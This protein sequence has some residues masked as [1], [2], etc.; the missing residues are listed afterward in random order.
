VSALT[1]LVL[2]SVVASVSEW[3]KISAVVSDVPKGG[4]RSV[5]TD[6]IRIVLAN[7][8]GEIYALEDVCSHQELPLSDG[9]LEG[10]R[11]ECPFHGAKF[12]VRTGRALNLPAVRPVRSF[13]VNVRDGDIFLK[14]G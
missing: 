6:T 9:E 3:T 2:R 7:V 5:E 13:D 11:L 14:L 12:D 1:V 4:L 10:T 8:E